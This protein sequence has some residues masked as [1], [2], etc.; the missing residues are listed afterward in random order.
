[1]SVLQRRVAAGSRLARFPSH[2]SD[3]QQQQQQ[4]QCGMSCPS[5][6]AVKKAYRL[7]VLGSARTG[8]SSLV[9][10]FMDND[11]ED[12]YIPTIE[13]FHRKL[14]KIKNEVYQLD[15]IDC[16]G[17]DPFPAARRLSYISGDMFLIV[18]SVDNADSVV[19][20]ID[21]R[22]QINECKTSRGAASSCDTPCV[23]ILNKADIPE[24]RWQITE[25]E[26]CDLIEK[27]TGPS[28]IL[29]VCSAATNLNID[30]AFGKLFALNKCPKHMNPEVH[31]K[32]RNE[33]SADEGTGR[34]H[35]LRRMR[36][37]FSRENDS[38]TT[39]TDLNARRP[40]LRTDLLINRS[41]TS[42]IYTNFMN[43]QKHNVY[44]EA[45][46]VCDA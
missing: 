3:Q 18:S 42:V 15:I 28:D 33:L 5:S 41:K 8:K 4:Q 14:Y 10:R 17:N 24:Y 29:V 37:R 6:P 23:F 46:T 35:I 9:G 43:Q 16:S 1:M 21:I 39:Y 45:R 22:K 19:H 7:V 30:K 44:D 40:S 2:S 26:A 32:L 34:R 27:S 31:K 20:M 11:F 12:R 25:K 38:L 36:S 13:N